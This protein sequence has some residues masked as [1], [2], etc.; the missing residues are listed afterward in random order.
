MSKECERD[1]SGDIITQDVSDEFCQD[2]ETFGPENAAAMDVARRWAALQP[3]RVCDPANVVI[4][5]R[6]T[7]VKL[8][9]NA[10][11]K[12]DDC[13]IFMVVASARS[14]ETPE[15][16]EKGC[17][18]I[19]VPRAPIEAILPNYYDDGYGA[20]VQRIIRAVR[21]AL[22][23][24]MNTPIVFAF[25]PDDAPNQPAEGVTDEAPA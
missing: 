1:T 7:A 12:V 16:E 2:Y 21:T 24:L 17:L 20:D 9:V 3:G 5:N 13:T 4:I 6:A 19:L 15:T 11:A 25:V 22:Q 8:G 23:W 10:D 18:L 14:S